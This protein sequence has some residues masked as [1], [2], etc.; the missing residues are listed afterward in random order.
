M[1][2]DSKMRLMAD[3]AGGLNPVSD[4]HYPD[5]GVQQ[6][7][8]GSELL[9][10]GEC[11]C[12][13][14]RPNLDSQ[15]DMAPAVALVNGDHFEDLVAPLEDTAPEGDQMGDQASL[16]A[17][18]DP[19]DKKLVKDYEKSV[20]SLAQAVKALADSS[21]GALNELAEDIEDSMLTLVRKLKIM[22]GL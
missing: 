4:L 15:P 14:C 22:K 7:P 9:L 21:D 3:F 10:D 6:Y 18:L 12:A 20:K 5:G 11:V 2:L 16:Y 1:K 13:S 8:E 19:Q 17:N